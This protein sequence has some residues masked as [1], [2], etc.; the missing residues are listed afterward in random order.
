MKHYLQYA[1]AKK[2]AAE[3]LHRQVDLQLSNE[4]TEVTRMRTESD[5]NFRMP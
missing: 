5:N 1:E 2:D 4:T 3:L